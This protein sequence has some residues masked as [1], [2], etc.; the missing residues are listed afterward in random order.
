MPQ[1]EKI[2]E[3]KTPKL[4][5]IHLTKPTAN[6]L[7]NLR[8]KFGFHPLDIE[9]CLSPSQRP[10]LDEYEHYLFL[11]LTFP[12][13]E[14]GG[15]EIKASEID[16]FIGPNYLITVSDG[17]LTPL[18][19]FFEQCQIND[20][21]RQ[22]YLSDNPIVL[23]YE[24]VNRLQLYC[25]PILDHIG[26]DIDGIQKVIFSG[27]EK[28]MVKEILIIKRN[29]VN[30]RKI[31]Q[32]HKSVV[33]KLI[34]KKDKYFIPNSISIYFNNTLEQTK[35]IWD[36]LDNIN[37]TINALHST[38][39]SLISFRLNDIMKLLTTITVT[40]LPITLTAGIFGMNTPNMPLV[41]RPAGF[42]I[43]IG[44]MLTLIFGFVV[45]FKKKKF[46]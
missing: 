44:I 9:D 31:M 24:I 16:F 11:I 38:N 15:R 6:Q 35:D 32:A 4:H 33:K 8:L 29:I 25:Y 12:Y 40:L 3:I 36:I 18:I 20:T 13:Y 22:K 27:Y 28:K 23:L 37:E 5:W 7:E 34:S 46:L 39:E 1:A 45:Y 41:N 30:F 21:L 42:W 14:P 2:I 10:K 43:I 17:M 19:K 26:E